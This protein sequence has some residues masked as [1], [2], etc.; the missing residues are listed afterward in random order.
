MSGE[1]A[2]VVNDGVETKLLS[3]FLPLGVVTAGERTTP[4]VGVQVNVFKCGGLAVGVLHSHRIADA[5]TVATFIDAWTEVGRV[6][7]WA[8]S[9][10]QEFRLN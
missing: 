1:L 3:R 7:S 8:L 9:S 5:Y 4:L 2:S 6:S 10:Q